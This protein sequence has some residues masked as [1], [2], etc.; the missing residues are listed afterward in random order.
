METLF[1]VFILLKLWLASGENE[2]GKK[3]GA[4]DDVIRE[5]KQEIWPNE[6]K[7]RR[8]KS[9]AAWPCRPFVG[10]K[11][12]YFFSPTQRIHIHYVEMHNHT[13][14][15][16][17]PQHPYTHQLTN[18]WSRTTRLIY[19]QRTVSLLCSTF[20]WFETNTHTRVHTH[21]STGNTWGL[22]RGS[23]VDEPAKG[24]TPTSINRVNV[25]KVYMK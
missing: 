16:Q 9:T 10:D 15:Y 5:V 12:Q 18:I 22:V 8:L 4:N 24:G 11:Y 14:K 21:T 6:Q 17:Y 2:L 13:S 7:T 25:I 3:Y 19:K 23:E 20:L 1:V